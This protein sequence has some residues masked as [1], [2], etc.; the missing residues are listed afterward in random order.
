M[1]DN[2]P[3][4]AEIFVI[5]RQGRKPGTTLPKLIERQVESPLN[6]L[7]RKVAIKHQI[8]RDDKKKLGQSR[9][10]ARGKTVR[11]VAKGEDRVG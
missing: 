7:E 3:N 5:C 11:R 4:V 6:S 10:H 2:P 1:N 9:R 8:K